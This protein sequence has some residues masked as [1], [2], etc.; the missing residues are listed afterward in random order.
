MI[1]R[2]ALAALVD[3]YTQA[4]GHINDAATALE[5]ASVMVGAVNRDGLTTESAR[6]I[7]TTNN[8]YQAV[9]TMRDRLHDI[10]PDD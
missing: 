10:T 9:S 7:E 2:Q 1:S 4:L 3:D 6:L 8:L 5:T